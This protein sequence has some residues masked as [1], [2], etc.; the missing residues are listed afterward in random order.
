MNRAFH[1]ARLI[2]SNPA[3]MKAVILSFVLISLMGGQAAA[4]HP[5]IGTWEMISV[6]GIGADGE[7]FFLDTTDVKETKIIT[8]T[9][10]MLIAWDVDGDSLT[11]NR[12]MAGQIRLEGEK[13]IEIPTQASVQI[14]ENVKV[15]FTWKLDG[16]VFTQSGTIIRPDGKAVLLEALK[17]KR[18][19]DE[20]AHPE[21]PGTGTWH[22]L[23]G[24]YTTT[25]GKNIPT[26]NE[27]DSRLLIITP[28]HWMRMD[29]KNKKFEGV[30]Y[31]TYTMQGD[32]VDNVLDFST[33]PFTK[34][35]RMKQLQ[36]PAGNKIHLTSSGQA[37]EG[38]PVTFY[39]VFEKVE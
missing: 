5:L 7:P 20:K 30:L 28:T 32:A 13:Y 37:P 14:F 31:G 15:D 22:Q 27:A 39:E 9:H 2:L 34:G 19:T 1:Q 38:N 12:T 18:V 25:D 23:S 24:H 21:N 4:Q 29:L 11:F 33:Y 10:Y 8:P 16:E 26:F 36:R 35:Q 6:K 17:F 3:F